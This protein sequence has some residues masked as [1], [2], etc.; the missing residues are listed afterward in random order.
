[1]CIAELVYNSLIGELIDPVEGVPNAFEQGSDC[2][3]LYGQ[4]LEA[5]ARLRDR[6]GVTDEDADVEIIIDSLLRIQRALC[7][8][9]F[10]LARKVI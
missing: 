7:I 1:M 3:N 9:M 2:E 6:L 8:E 10:R 4:M 5:Y